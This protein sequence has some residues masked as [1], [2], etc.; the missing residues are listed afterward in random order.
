LANCEEEEK[1]RVSLD[2]VDKMSEKEVTELSSSKEPEPIMTS[3][4]SDS[5]SSS[6]QSS[7]SEPIPK[8]KQKKEKRSKSESKREKKKKQKQEKAKERKQKK[9]EKARNA[10]ASRSRNLNDDQNSRPANNNASSSSRNNNNR[11]NSANYSKVMADAVAAVDAR[12]AN[13]NKRNRDCPARPDTHVIPDQ[14]TYGEYIYSVS[15][16]LKNAVRKGKLQ[17]YSQIVQAVDELANDPR[18]GDRFRGVHPDV[19]DIT[20]AIECEP[21]YFNL[22]WDKEWFTIPSLISVFNNDPMFCEYS[23]EWHESVYNHRRQKE[24][25][26]TQWERNNPKQS[27]VLPV[28][29]SSNRSSNTMNNSAGFGK[30]VERKDSRTF[31]GDRTYQ[32]KGVAQQAFNPPDDPQPNTDSDSIPYIVYGSGF[33]AR[34]T[35]LEGDA[36]LGIQTRVVITEELQME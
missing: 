28:P 9:E 11:N 21:S 33:T 36:P 1:Q 19:L 24:E 4:D 7:S 13:S 18:W 17:P 34:I 12:A 26:Q 3:S 25:R 10:S 30:K 20:V 8:K 15:S 5:D 27:P 6:K 16:A 14:K 29:T 31:K 2:I 23:S 32:G 35:S 22:H